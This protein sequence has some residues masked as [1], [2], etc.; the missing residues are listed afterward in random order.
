MLDRQYDAALISFWCKFVALFAYLA[1]AFAGLA[2]YGTPLELPDIG[3]W[4]G[5]PPR[6]AFLLYLAFNALLEERPSC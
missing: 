6:L 2:F 4:L 5:V 3:G 1:D